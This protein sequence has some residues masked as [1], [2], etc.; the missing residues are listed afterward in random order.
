[1]VLSAVS[2]SQMFCVVGDQ[3]KKIRD[4]REHFICER[5]FD[6]M[7]HTMMMMGDVLVRSVDVTDV[8][9]SAVCARERDSRRSVLVQG[10]LPFPSPPGAFVA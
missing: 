3:K 8:V 10:D 6:G 7:V 5:L 2:H 4:M 9:R 1:M